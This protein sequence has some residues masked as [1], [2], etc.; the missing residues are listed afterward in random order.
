MK[1]HVVTKLCQVGSMR[2]IRD[3]INFPIKSPMYL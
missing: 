1:N 2:A 3:K